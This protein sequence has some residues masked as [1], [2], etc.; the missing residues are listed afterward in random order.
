MPSLLSLPELEPEP[1]PDA[2]DSE[3]GEFD[4]GE[5][6]SGDSDGGE[7]DSGLLELLPAGGG[8]GGF[9]GGNAICLSP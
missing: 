6:D 8:T 9:F 5:A 2:G 7:A 1:E 4:G 3:G